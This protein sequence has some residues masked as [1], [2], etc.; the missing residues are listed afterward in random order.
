MN[1]FGISLKKAKKQEKASNYQYSTQYVGQNGFILDGKQIARNYLTYSK[2]FRINTDIRRCV[3]EI[4]ETSAKSGYDIKRKLGDGREKDQ[5]VPDFEECMRE[6]GGFN[7]LKSEIIKNVSIFGN[8]YIRKHMNVRGGIIK[9]SVLDSRYVSITTDPE[10]NPLRYQY[11]PPYKKGSAES[12]EMIEII[13][14][15]DT[16][17][18]DN[19]AFGMSIMETL[20]LDVMWDEEASLSNYHFFG[21]DSIPSA[22]FILKDG[23]SNDQAKD[24]YEQVKEALSWGH[25]K[26]KNI[27]S[28]AIQDVKPIR[29]DHTDM[30][31]KDQRAQTTNK[32]CAA[33][34]VPRTILGY[35]ED[36]NHS[37]GQSQ[38]EK[39]IENTIRPWEKQLNEI[40][41]EVLRSI[42][43]G[44]QLRFCIV[45]EHIDDLK[46]RSQLA[47]DNVEKGIWT[48]NEAREYLWYDKSTNELAD[49]LTVQTS[50]QL[51]DSLTANAVET[52]PPPD[53]TQPPENQPPA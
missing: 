50:Q 33:F 27:V 30:A 23:L 20:V 36:V 6:S 42:A 52:Q 40:F 53:Q 22:L 31:F 34:W 39:F 29:Q 11:A 17:D 51:L 8:A 26:H 7:V 38:Y 14:I 45:D 2:M 21:N 37:N 35:V 25:N 28:Q 43:P 10:L 44:V 15:K 41:T 5:D 48:R 49:E 4:S 24:Q 19:P 47:R 13:H 12:Y 9:L 32:V 3:K 18:P 1:I 46:E 16:I